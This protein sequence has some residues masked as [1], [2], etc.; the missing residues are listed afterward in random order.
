MVKLKKIICLIFAVLFS[1]TFVGCTSISDL[2]WIWLKPE[3]KPEADSDVPYSINKDGEIE[4][5]EEQMYKLLEENGYG[6]D[7]DWAHQSDDD[8]NIPKSMDIT[9]SREFIR[10]TFY[11][12]YP[13]AK[14]YEPGDM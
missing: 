8:P 12:Q 10:D 3:T 14:E 1:G 5:T 13:K 4:M 9:A 6:N 2:P 7:V 11:D